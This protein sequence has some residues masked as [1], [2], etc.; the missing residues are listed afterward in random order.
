MT[1][2]E[3]GMD[4][5]MR[6]QQQFTRQQE[7][8][9]DRQKQQ[10]E[11]GKKAQGVLK[12]L[13]DLQFTMTI[14]QLQS[15]ATPEIIAEVDALKSKPDTEDLRRM[16]SGMAEDMENRLETIATT[17][18]EAEPLINSMRVLNILMDLYFSLK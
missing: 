15:I 14:Q 12:G 2:E 3:S 5:L 10:V 1:D 16:I 7:E 6:L 9:D 8:H 4:E 17:D 11:Q 13:K 18:S